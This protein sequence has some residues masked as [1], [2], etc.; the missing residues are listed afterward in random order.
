MRVGVEVLLSKTPQAHTI[1][2]A[3]HRQH[4]TSAMPLPTIMRPVRFA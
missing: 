3:M 2:A 4:A 1:N